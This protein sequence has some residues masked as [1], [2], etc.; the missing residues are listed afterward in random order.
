MKT[1]VQFTVI[2]SGDIGDIT[3]S[4]A[5]AVARHIT[6][7]LPTVEQVL[8]SLRELAFIAETVG[9]LRGMTSAID[10]GDRA[11]TIITKLEAK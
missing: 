9:H 8:A 4:E 2:L 10:A 1:E 5:A 6:K 11:R 7:Q 3:T